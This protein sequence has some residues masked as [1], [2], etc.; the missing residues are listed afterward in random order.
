MQSQEPRDKS[1]R[2]GLRR[3][4]FVRV[5]GAGA[6]GIAA[7]VLDGVGARMLLQLR[8]QAK[9]LL[10][11]ATT[12][13]LLFG[14]FVDEHG[15]SID[16]VVAAPLAREDS[17]T[18]N[19]Q[20]ELSCHGGVGV[21]AA[22]EE[23]LLAA[24]FARGQPRDLL[25]RAHLNATLPLVTIEARLCLAAAATARQA[26]FLLSHARFQERWERLGFNMVLATRNH[27]ESWRGKL[28][29]EANTAL[30]QFRA[31][32]RLLAQHRV[33]L[34]GPVNAG[35]STLGNRLA[36]AERHIVSPA[37]G[38][39][40]DHLETPIEL[41]GLNVLLADTAGLRTALDSVESE[42]QKRAA[43]AAREADLRLLIFD[44]SQPPGDAD[45]ELIARTTACG[46]TLLVLNK[47]DLG[48]DESAGGLG[49]LAGR[50]PLVVSA[51]TG[52]GLDKLLDAIAGTLL[53]GQEPPAGAP[54]TQR[55]A[56]LLRQL[57]HGL[58]EGQ[59]VSELVQ[60]VRTLVGTRPDEAELS[61]V[62]KA[63]GS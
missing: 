16:E 35:K 26:A 48:V 28:F 5:T 43:E 11:E 54:F 13:D 29:Q 58:Q 37:P 49:F 25:R 33:A 34:T 57:K 7:L 10:A 1:Q 52:W 42:G 39:T 21:L 2:P 46:P 55:Q 24:G 41:C 47:Q 53:D 60:Y 44:G 38:T 19:E 18:G 51:K 36:R 9:R 62:L 14:Q 15:G 23:A 30:E 59:T 45:V 8:F 50:E 63:P 27:D 56:N 32:Q 4:I 12:G 6:G 20:V 40:V 17:E 3:P 31:A 22:V 61:E